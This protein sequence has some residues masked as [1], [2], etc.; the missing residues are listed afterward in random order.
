MINN[1]TKKQE[2]IYNRYAD[3]LNNKDF[4]EAIYQAKLYNQSL[5]KN[6]T[7]LYLSFADV[8]IE[9]LQLLQKFFG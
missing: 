3:S 7:D 4:L 2:L 9:D 5:T 8:V 6:Q 1:E